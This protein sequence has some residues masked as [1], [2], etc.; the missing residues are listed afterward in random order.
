MQGREAEPHSH[1]EDQRERDHVGTIQCRSTG[2]KLQQARKWPNISLTGQ[3]AEP[4]ESVGY[5]L[6]VD[7]FASS[8]ECFDLLCTLD[9]LIISPEPFGY[10]PQHGPT[11]ASFFCASLYS[12]RSGLL[13]HIGLSLDG[14]GGATKR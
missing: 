12:F 4:A 7:I 11:I 5:L 10:C 8:L 3:V 14:T 6:V 9:L 13:H 1:G 2:N